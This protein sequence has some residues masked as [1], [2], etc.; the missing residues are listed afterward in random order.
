MCLQCGRPGFDPW[1]GK[2]T[3]R[4]ERPPTPVFWPGEFHG[5]YSPWGHKESDTTGRLSLSLIWWVKLARLSPLLSPQDIPLFLS[6]GSQLPLRLRLPPGTKSVH[7]E[8]CRLEDILCN[9]NMITLA[10]RQ[11]TRSGVPLMTVALR[12]CPAAD[13]REINSK[14]SRFSGS[15]LPKV[16]CPPTI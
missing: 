14:H 15:R 9:Y 11:F 5:P 1:V 7:E 2:I 4:R 10:N 3:W 16:N 8:C 6:S 13:S 12:K